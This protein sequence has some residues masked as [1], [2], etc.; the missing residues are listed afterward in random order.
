MAIFLGNFT[1]DGVSSAIDHS[2]GIGNFTVEG[3]FDGATAKL[4]MSRD[5]GVTYIDVPDGAFTSSSSTNYI[6]PYPVKFRV[7]VSGGG[8]SLDINVY[9]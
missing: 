5:N 1:V 4:Q 7:D 3:T 2:G 8:G 9:L 6:E